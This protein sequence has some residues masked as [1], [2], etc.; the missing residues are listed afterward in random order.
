MNGHVGKN[1]NGFNTVHGGGGH[2]DGNREGEAIL[3][4]AV[5]HGLVILN[6]LFKKRESHLVTYESGGRRSQID[7]IMT[8]M[9]DK[10]KTGNK[11]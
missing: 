11:T 3:D 1:N 6:T 8:R 9:Q 10:R 7:Y 5:A 4:E 2:G